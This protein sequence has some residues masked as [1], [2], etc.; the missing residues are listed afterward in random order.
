MYSTKIQFP[1]SVDMTGS[2]LSRTTLGDPYVKAKRDKKR[3]TLFDVG[4]TKPKKPRSGAIVSA[5][6][7][8]ARTAARPQVRSGTGMYR[9]ATTRADPLLV[10]AL[11]FHG[12][13]KVLSLMLSMT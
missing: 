12:L 5:G 13:L 3:R 6:G 11:L 7:G 4:V 2:K 9:L 8:L 1:N 10:E